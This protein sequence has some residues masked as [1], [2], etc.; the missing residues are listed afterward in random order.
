MIRVNLLPGKREARRAAAA[1]GGSSAIT[2][3]DGSST[4]L[5]FVLG[6]LLATILVCA[7][8]WTA[9]L[10]ELGKIEG[11]NKELQASIDGIKSQISDHPRIKSRLKELKDR[12]EAI[13]K[14]QSARTGPT[15]AMMELSHILSPGRGPSMDNARVEQLR[16][17]NP[18]ALPNPNWDTR[19][20]WLSQYAELNRDVRISGL[21]RD[22]EDVS[23][24]LR[25][26]TM[27]DYFYDVKL[28]PASKGFDSVTKIEVVKFQISAKARY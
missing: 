4:W 12:E 17:D 22:G 14:L 13:D 9:K 25:R 27:S 5:L 3:S 11:K 20:L 28:L 23:E 6:A 15:S 10:R 26:M 16:R 7:F 24:F 19:R 18:S 2:P 8:V 21:A 1:G